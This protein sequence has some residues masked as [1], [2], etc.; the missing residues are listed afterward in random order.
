MIDHMVTAVCEA[1]DL[2]YEAYPMADDAWVA[3]MV[4][5]A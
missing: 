5:A 3:A 2:D 4:R 1:Y